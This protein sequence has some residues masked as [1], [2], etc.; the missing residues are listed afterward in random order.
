MLIA[1]L[2]EAG[3]GPVIGPLVIGC[4]VMHQ[5]DLHILDEIGVDDSKHLSPKKR[6]FLAGEIKRVCLIAKTLVISAEKL[7]DMHYKKKLTL[8]QIEEQGFAQLINELQQKPQA[9]FLDAC[10]VNEDRFGK[11]IGKML[12][13]TPDQIV[14]KHKGDAIFKI[15]GATSAKIPTD[16]TKVRSVAG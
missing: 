5:K 12:T 15:V 11:T 2:D 1:G 8:N 14:S 9:I 7:N 13:F 3:R 16:G 6:G 4:V 10:D